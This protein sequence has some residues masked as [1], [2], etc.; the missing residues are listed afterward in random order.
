MSRNSAARQN[1]RPAAGLP[2]ALAA[3]LFAVMVAAAGPARAGL[4]LAQAPVVSIYPV[5]AP[6]EPLV[7][8]GEAFLV[9]VDD[10]GGLVAS[11]RARWEAQTIPC[12]PGPEGKRWIGVGGVGREA[13]PG[14]KL[15]TVYIETTM[16]FRFALEKT[17]TVHER[18][19]GKSNIRVNPAMIE[20]PE[21]HKP[22]AEKDRENFSATWKTADL[23]RYWSG[24]F[25]RPC[26]GRVTSAFG[27]VRTYNGVYTTAH[28]G[29]DIA[30]SVGTPI[31]ATQAGEVALVRKAY[32][33]GDTVVIDHGGGVFTL[34]YHLS[35]FK[36][37][38]GDMVERGDVIGLV[39]VTGRI[40][41]PHLHWGCRVQGTLVDP[42]SLLRLEEY[43]APDPAPNKD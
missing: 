39:G 9:V 35:E 8:Q 25:Q 10:S 29:A 20:T 13:E 21:K 34:Y 7:G 18:E 27:K 28:G 11:A 16:G 37:S 14:E 43:L 15:L 1:E 3:L 33:Q 36:V 23:A 6:G 32:I 24:P 2:R 17:F 41:G 30:A 42:T 12:L 22:W 26:P 5:N 31:K 19:F 40:T 38:E 4:S